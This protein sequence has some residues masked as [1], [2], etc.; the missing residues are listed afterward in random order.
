M[1]IISGFEPAVPSSN[2]GEGTKNRA[3]FNR[4]KTSSLPSKQMLGV[5]ISPEAQG[6]YNAYEKTFAIFFLARDFSNFATIVIGRF[7]TM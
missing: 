4:V 6:I 2:L 7:S 5:L 1:D 3:K